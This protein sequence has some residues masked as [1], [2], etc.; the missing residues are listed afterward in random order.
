MKVER[1]SNLTKAILQAAQA[2]AL[3]AEHARLEAIHVLHAMLSD[4]GGLVGLLIS[5]AGGDAELLVSSVRGEVEKLARVSGDTGHLALAPTAQKL[6]VRAEQT[7]RLLAQLEE[8]GF[9]T[10]YG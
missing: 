9:N 2:E 8:H 3:G 6:L 1:Y 5:D 4:V 7:R 10:L